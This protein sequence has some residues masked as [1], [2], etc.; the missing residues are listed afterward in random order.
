M[1]ASSTGAARSR[2]T[3]ASGA[4]SKDVRGA[5]LAEATRLFREHGVDGFSMRQIAD[6]IGYSATTI[7]LHFKDKNHLMYAVCESGFAEFGASLAAAAASESDA[8][9]RLRAIGRAYVDFAL[10]HPLH[11]DVM[12][13][14]PKEWAI[15][16]LTD[17]RVGVGP[18]DPQ[19]ADPESFAE[20]VQ[21]V[22]AAVSARVFEGTIHQ[23]ADAREIAM[24]FWAAIH[25]V[26]AL[27]ISMNDQMRGF[28]HDAVR[29]RGE[30]AIDAAL[31]AS[32]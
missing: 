23:G 9:E 17:A 24:R 20:L 8:R 31:G 11:Y 1:A 19:R 27:A 13:I 28:D 32:R 6:A 21:A 16:P 3:G 12:F 30:V 22:E 15:G 5:I 7:Y 25:G 2:A 10:T 29:A 4:P 26:V 14:R 18:E